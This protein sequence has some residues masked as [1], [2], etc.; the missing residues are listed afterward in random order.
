MLSFCALNRRFL[1][2]IQL[3]NFYR[4]NFSSFSTS[5]KRYRFW[6]QPRNVKYI[7]ETLFEENKINIRMSTNRE[8]CYER[9]IT[10]STF[11]ETPVT[12]VIFLRNNDVWA[13]LFRR[14]AVS[15]EKFRP[16]KYKTNLLAMCF[17]VIFRVLNFSSIGKK[18]LRTNLKSAAAE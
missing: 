2:K 4:V 17:R 5:E 9:P 11:H 10:A 12:A 7:M 16:G 1:L 18:R 8:I 15:V 6:F 3:Q 13:S 14:S